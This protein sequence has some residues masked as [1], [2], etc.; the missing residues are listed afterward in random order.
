M[1]INFTINYNF[2]IFLFC[3]GGGGGG[4]GISISQMNRGIW[5]LSIHGIGNKPLEKQRESVGFRGI[6]EINFIIIC[7]LS[8]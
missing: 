8:F 5:I 2:W 6:V 1:E 7:F 4:T 3:F